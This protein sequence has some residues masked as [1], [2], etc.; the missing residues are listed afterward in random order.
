MSDKITGYLCLWNIP[1]ISIKHTDI[2]QLADDVAFDKDFIPKV[3]RRRNAWEKATNLGATGKRLTPPD[4]KVEEVLQM[5]G[6][7]PTVRLYTAIVSGSAPRLVRHIVRRVTIPTQQ[8][9]GGKRKLAER[10]L[11][12]ETVCIME[13]STKSESFKS[14]GQMELDDSQHFVN[15]ELRGVVQELH[16]KVSKA[17][18]YADANDVRRG[19]RQ[20]LEDKNAVLMGSG[21]GYFVPDFV[22]ALD[23]LKSAKSYLEA[24]HPYQVKPGEQKKPQLLVF[25]L[26]ESGDT[27][28][29]RLDVANNAID[30]FRVELQDLT[31]ELAPIIA[32]ARTRV[33]GSKLRERCTLRFMEINQQIAQYRSVLDDNLSA[34]DVYIQSASSFIVSAQT[35]EF[36]PLP[37]E[38]TE[39][40][41][42]H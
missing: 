37:S 32:G 1:E 22:G 17:V 23:D 38:A 39:D 15:G 4:D 3:P 42:D 27:F 41:Q 34:L 33:V 26:S 31:D 2:E 6:A 19:L 24:M 35:V 25:P 7:K 21:G 29:A 8:D 16:G 18:D 40:N 28:E 12:Q 9:A 30:R 36:R 13:F 20:W 5:Y 10:Q 14:T 11:D